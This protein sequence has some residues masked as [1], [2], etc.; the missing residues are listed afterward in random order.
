[1]SESG[2]FPHWRVN[3]IDESI[4]EQDFTPQLPIHR[5]IYFML[6]QKGIPNVPVWYPR[7]VEAKAQLGAETFNDLNK[8]YYSQQSHFLTNTMPFNGAYVVRLVPTDAAKA[9]KLVE[10]RVE[11]AEI[12]QYVLDANG[13]RTVDGNGDHVIARVDQLDPNSAIITETGTK[14]TWVTRTVVSADQKNGLFPSREATEN[15]STVNYYPVFLF[16]ASSAGDWGNDLGFKLFFDAAENAVDAVDRVD[17]AF[18]S[19]APVVKEYNASTVDPV[20]DRFGNVS[21]SFVMSPETVDAATKL[22]VDMEATIRRGYKG[23]TALPY[24]ITAFPDNISAVGAIIKGHEDTINATLD[25]AD[26]IIELETAFNANILTG[27]NIDGMYYRSVEMSTAAITGAAADLEIFTP[28]SESV[29]YLNGGSDGTITDDSMESLVR[30]YVELDTYPEIQ[31]NAR[32]PI[33]HIFDVGFSLQT[34]TALADFLAVRDDVKFVAAS[35]QSTSTSVNG[36]LI[37]PTINDRETDISM[38]SSVKNDIVLT[39]ES[40]IKG[41]YACRGTVF[42]QAGHTYGNYRKIVPST[43]WYAMKLA[44]YHNTDRMDGAPEGTPHSVIDIFEDHGWVAYNEDI[45]Q[46]GWD[47]SLNYFQYADST[48]LHYASLQSVY[49]NDTSVLNID[50]VTNA[51][52]YTKHEIRQ[53]WTKY[54]GVTWAASEVHTAAKEDLEDRLARLYNGRYKFSVTVYQ[55]DEEKQLGYKHHFRVELLSPAG[56]RIAEADVVCKRENFNN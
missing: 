5:A 33:T 54:A 8:K 39:P 40:V 22:A 21:T 52:V 49:K 36:D 35:Q 4:F 7:M 32:Y 37:V 42:M 19:L 18:W 11:E 29:F 38:G 41:T 50:D 12:T 24:A 15:G 55:T 23:K 28:N 16:E 44:E 56:F 10:L 45:K 26:P 20:R 2:S 43:L 9:V 6:A 1:M 13:N 48:R 47:E 14:L 34:K 51:I 30:N 27:R 17:A 25:V 3:V 31:D 53:V 46:L